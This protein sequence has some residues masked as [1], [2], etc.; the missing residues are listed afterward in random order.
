[1][2]ATIPTPACQ[3]QR[4]AVTAHFD[5]AHDDWNRYY[6]AADR[7]GIIFRSRLDLALRL[8]R[9]HVLR[10][11]HALD[12]GC[13]AGPAAIALAATG[14]QVIGIDIS[15]SMIATADRLAAERD[16][17][18]RCRFLSADFFELGLAPRTFDLIVALGFIE[19]FDD[20]S[21]VLERI[22]NLL[23][24]TGIAVVQ[25]TNR[26]AM[27]HLLRGTIGRRIEHTWSGLD[28]RQFGPGEFA[29]IARGAGLRRIDY[30]G[31][32]FGPLKIGGRFIPGYRAAGWIERR[33]D[34]LAGHRI[35][36]GLGRFGASIVNVLAPG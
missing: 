4:L 16:L 22:R 20:P 18:D 14:H 33:M 19:Y 9:R 35:A 36:R 1:M 31:H 11:G 32:G 3:S 28:A 5:A 10:A 21:A 23:A 17:S 15:P 27:K 2:T 8:C 6:D 7:S 29:R 25:I 24:S 26:V 12:L 34:Q 30:R 13:G